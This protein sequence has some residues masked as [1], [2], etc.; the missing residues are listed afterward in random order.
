MLHTILIKIIEQVEYI[1]SVD[2]RGNLLYLCYV[3][4]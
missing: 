1:L 2:E 3:A 4:K